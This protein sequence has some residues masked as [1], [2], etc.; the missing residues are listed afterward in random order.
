MKEDSI[1]FG[2][3]LDDPNLFIPWDI[4]QKKLI[5]LFQ[6]HELKQVTNGYFTTSCISLGGLHHRL[7]F[8]FEPQ[9]SNTLKKIEF[10]RDDY[11]DLEFSFNEFQKFFENQ[12]GYPS[13]SYPKSQEGF[14]SYEWIIKN[15]IKIYHFI[16]DR[17]GLEER[18]YIERI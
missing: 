12:F 6:G 9:K 16:F 8:H 10:F 18:L 14:Y 7:G 4:T 3:Q 2:F 15:K 1:I 17:F 5:D 11:S 13:K